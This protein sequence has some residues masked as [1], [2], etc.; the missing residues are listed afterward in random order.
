MPLEKKRTLYKCGENFVPL[1]QVPTVLDSLGAAF[2]KTS[3]K[4]LKKLSIWSG[5]ITRLEIDAIVN[6]ANHTLLGG[7]GV[8][9]AIHRAAGP[10]LKMETATLNGCQTGD[11]KITLGYFLPAKHVIHTVG[12]VGEKPDLLR[13]CYRRCLDIC[14]ENSLRSVAFPCIST[15]VYH[16]PNRKACEVALQTVK[17]W[18]ETGD[19]L[20]A[21]DRIIFCVFLDEDRALY[22][23]LVPKYFGA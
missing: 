9:G 21:L 2:S 14:K 17:Q 20:Q 7:G 12:P 15:G 13:S 5:D 11:A 19:N 16:Y 6:A 18:L 22:E 10:S 23:E 8:D 1:D 4:M 3:E